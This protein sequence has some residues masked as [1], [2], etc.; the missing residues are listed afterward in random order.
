MGRGS[1]GKTSGSEKAN[2][3]QSETHG[4]R[5]D[6]YIKRQIG[7]DINQ[8]R[9]D[10]TKKYESKNS[11]VLYKVPEPVKQQIKMLARKYGRIDFVTQDVGSWGTMITTGK[12]LEEYIKMMDKLWG[13]GKW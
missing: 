10:F 6:K 8:Y 5:L 12:E 13:K 4:E 7:V 11:V 3:I 9:D 2:T 1:S